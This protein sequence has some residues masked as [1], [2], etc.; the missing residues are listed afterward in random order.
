METHRGYSSLVGLQKSFEFYRMVQTLRT[1]DQR[2][3]VVVFA[4]GGVSP[5]A[6]AVDHPRVYCRHSRRLRKGKGAPAGQDKSERCSR[7]C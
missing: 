6:A 7:H 5:R 1:R 3:V 2:P 4:D